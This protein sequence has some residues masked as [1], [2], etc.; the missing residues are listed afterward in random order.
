VPLVALCGL[1]YAGYSPTFVAA[2]SSAVALLASYLTFDRQFWVTPKVLVEC[3]VETLSRLAGSPLLAPPP[4]S[5]SA[6]ST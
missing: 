2:G 5:S 1:I 4:A 6:I 3:C